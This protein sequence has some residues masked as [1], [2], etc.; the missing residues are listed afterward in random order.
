MNLDLFPDQEKPCQSTVNEFRNP[1]PERLKALEEQKH[2]CL[3]R[4]LLA[5]RARESSQSSLTYL[6]EKFPNL[7]MDVRAQW[8]KGNRGVWN[9]WR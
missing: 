5:K 6:R 8:Q 2:Q 9:D 7:E 4:W 3:V 1:L